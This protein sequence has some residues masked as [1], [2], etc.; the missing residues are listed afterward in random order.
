MALL[1]LLFLVVPI[2]ELYVIIQV[3]QEIGALNTI[4]LLLLIS[5]VGAWLAKREGVGVWRRLN[6][7]VSAGRVPGAELIDAFLILLA[8]ALLL[9]PGFISDVI[10]IFLLIPPTRALVRRVLRRRFVGKVEIFRGSASPSRP[11]D[12]DLP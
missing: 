9:T 5:V 11:P 10:A 8:G 3:G 2:V 1:V 6:Q 7:Q 4:G 12:I